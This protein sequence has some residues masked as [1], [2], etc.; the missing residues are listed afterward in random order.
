VEKKAIPIFEAT[1]TVFAF[2]NSLSYNTFTTN[3][4][5]TK[6]MNINPE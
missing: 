5:N 6:A 4:L 3:A 2:N 1:I